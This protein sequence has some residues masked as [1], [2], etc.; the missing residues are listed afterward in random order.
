MKNSIRIRNTNNILP[1]LNNEKNPYILEENYNFSG[2]KF[3]IMETSN[4]DYYL[5]Q[6]SKTKINH[7]NDTYPN[8]GFNYQKF[9]VLVR[10]IPKIFLKETY[11]EYFIQNMD[12]LLISIIESTKSI[13]HYYNI[14]L[15]GYFKTFN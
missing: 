15:P 10:S 9:G 1:E 4:Y 14:Y 7:R 12:K 13:K 3:D 5:E 11:R 6:T 2:D 8:I